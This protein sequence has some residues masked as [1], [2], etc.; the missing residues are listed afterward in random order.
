MFWSALRAEN[1]LIETCSELAQRTCA[2]RLRSAT[3]TEQ[4]AHKKSTLTVRYAFGPPVVLVVCVMFLCMF[5][6]VAFVPLLFDFVPLSFLLVYP[7]WQVLDPI[8]TI[9]TPSCQESAVLPQVRP[10]VLGECG[11]RKWRITNL[12]CT[13]IA[14]IQ[15]QPDLPTRLQG[16]L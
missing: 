4:I 8:C 1:L 13:M 14:V 15:K 3:C 5:A 11:S 12:P 2:E 10:R 16:T 6:Y 7:Q 9:C